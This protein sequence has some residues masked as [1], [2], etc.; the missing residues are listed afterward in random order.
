MWTTVPGRVAVAKTSAA[1]GVTVG[2]VKGNSHSA[3][4]GDR[5]M[6]P[7]LRGWPNWSCHSAACRALPS[8][9][10]LCQRDVVGIRLDAAVLEV[11]HAHH[12]VLRAD[13]ERA[14]GRGQGTPLRRG[15]SPPGWRS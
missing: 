8:W 5:L 10:L 1:P 15:R 12:V 2:L 7:W 14:G 9:K 6:Q 3:A 11:V 4:W 13:A